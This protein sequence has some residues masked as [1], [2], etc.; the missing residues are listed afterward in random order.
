MCELLLW[1]SRAYKNSA[2]NIFATVVEAFCHLP[3]KPCILQGCLLIY[4]VFYVT[5]CH[6]FDCSQVKLMY[7]EILKFATKEIAEIWC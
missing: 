1:N 4:T 5:S 3:S 6:V 2:M 7:G